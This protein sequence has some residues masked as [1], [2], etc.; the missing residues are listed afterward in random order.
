MRRVRGC[1]GAEGVKA[2]RDKQ[3]LERTYDGLRPHALPHDNVVV[4][5]LAEELCELLRLRR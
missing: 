2:R 5:Q 1:E 4:E 3:R